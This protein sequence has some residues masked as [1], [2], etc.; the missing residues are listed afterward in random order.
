MRPDHAA[1][2]TKARHDTLRLLVGR[3]QRLGLNWEEGDLLREHLDAE[4]LDGDNARATIA[5]VRHALMNQSYLVSLDEAIGAALDP[6]DEV[7]G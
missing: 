4:I 7:T 6:A 3:A 5:R 1:D 2:D